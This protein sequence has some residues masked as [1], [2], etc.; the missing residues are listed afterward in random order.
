MSGL[1]GVVGQSLSPDVAMSFASAFCTAIPEGPVVIGRDGRESGPMLCSAISAAVTASGRD[2][3]DAG[4]VATPT[5]GVLVRTRTWKD[6]PVAGG[7]QISA[8]HNPP[9]YNGMKLF[10]ADGRVL[11][12]ELGKRV[13]DDYLAKRHHYV[14]YDQLGQV[15]LDQDPHATH[16][17]LVL[18]TVDVEAIRRSGFR[19]LLDSNHGAGGA[20]G[21]RLLAELGCDVILL[22]EEPTGQFSHVPEPTAD[23]L[24][25]I[26][27]QVSS[28]NADVGF[29]QDPDADRLAL[30]D[31]T[32]R[33]IGEECTLALCVTR[34]LQCDRTSPDDVIAINA[35]T[36]SMSVAIAAA[37]QVRTIRTAVGEANVCGGM[38]E[39]DAIYG[40]EGNGGPIDPRVGYVRDSFVAMAQVLD[41]MAA[42]NKPLSVLAGELP[43]FAMQKDKAELTD[44]S[45]DEIL[46]R[47]A[48][49]FSDAEV[50][51]SDGLRLQ[52]PD[53]WLLVRGSNTEPIIRFI[54]E[55]ETPE[56]AQRLCQLAKGQLNASR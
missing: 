35:A 53:R 51:R 15:H 30:I 25:D 19:V 2:I 12:A 54:A 38:I 46:E 6:Q 21:R 49:R 32:G 1:R 11:D 34:K 5:I 14:Q 56:E 20:L 37:H 33:Y 26:A 48:N 43:K 40:G 22:G 3:I 23:N 44:D 47:L 13:R 31:E 16:L 27:T 8:S 45:L 18:S 55:A 17:D 39:N 41:L 52:W 36:S 10:G 24:T 7:I 42:T 50:D 29:C 28:A 9:P 4:P